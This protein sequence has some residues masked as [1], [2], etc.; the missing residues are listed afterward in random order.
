M[1]FTGIN[2]VASYICTNFWEDWR[3]E[4]IEKDLADI[5]ELGLNAVRI[6]M[7]W[8]YMEP[9]E[10]NYNPKIF[11]QFNTFL[12]WCEK[13][14][15]YVMPWFLVGVA[16]RNYDVAF[17]NGRPFFTG[18][19]VDIAANHLKHFIKE[20]K[21]SEQILFWDICDEPE[22]YSL[23]KKG[24]EQLP[25]DR[26]TVD[27][28]LKKSGEALRGFAK[29]AKDA[30]IAEYSPVKAEA[31]IL[32]PE[33]YFDQIDSA[34]NL[35]YT[36]FILAKGCGIDIDLLWHNQDF[37]PYKL[38]IISVA[39]GFTTSLWEK[40]KKYVQEG[41]TVYYSSGGA[42]CFGAP[43][44]K[45]FGIEVQAQEKDYG[46]DRLHINRA[47]GEIEKNSILELSAKCNSYM[48]AEPITAEVIG[49]F[50]DGTPAMLVNQFGKGRA[51]L[52][53]KSL[54]NGMIDIKYSDFHQNDLFKVYDT[55]INDAGV[56]R[57]IK[58]DNPRIEIGHMINSDASE[59]MIICVNHDVSSV[60]VHL[61]LDISLVN[62]KIYDIFAGEY[63]EVSSNENG[64]GCMSVSFEPAGIRALKIKH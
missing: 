26:K 34:L 30:K 45:L 32:L 49:Q 64:N 23:Y 60:N 50:S 14:G 36:S 3:P 43:C 7:F 33:G 5:S 41:G 20:Y 15:L 4:I 21:H 52:S 53:V 1:I 31:A 38:I 9:E 63:V 24:A 62:G 2:Y 11:E 17:R 54:E 56:N 61:E 42:Y 55:L 16:T 44:N 59:S 10:G 58:C 57:F 37:S 39:S 27:G 13:Y 25:L 29:F 12:G 6:P 22:W 18:E 28:R 46:Y 19:M 48:R 47:W 8:G 35:T 51:F 40:T